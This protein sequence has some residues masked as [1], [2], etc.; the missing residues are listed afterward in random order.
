[1]KKKAEMGVGTLIIFIAM[2]LV[3]AVAAG[4]LIQTVG[5]LQEKS[6]S[7]GS[8]AKGQ[9]STNALTVEISATDGTDGSVDDFTHILKLAPGSE[10]IKLSDVILTFNT[11]TATATLKYRSGG[12][13]TNDGILGFNTRNAEEIG[14]LT[15]SPVDLEEDLDEDNITDTIAISDD[16]TQFQIN[17]SSVGVINVSAGATINAADVTVAV[18]NS[19]VTSGSTTYATLT[20]S[21]TSDANVSMPASATI[22]VTPSIDVGTGYFTVE[23]LQEG[24]NFVQDNL[25]RGDVIK[26]YYEAPS[27]IGEDE[28]LRIN[29]IPKVGTATLSQFVSP[30]VISTERVYLYP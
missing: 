13:L 24:T 30:D 7:T 12:T 28:E 22:T 6:L 19:A 29:F 5:S 27:S 2:L 11:Y 21:G 26:M 3:A 16:G 23:Y 8:Q 9:I 18:S 20:V 4:V 17:V 10:S 25:Q 15:N 1:M 14:A